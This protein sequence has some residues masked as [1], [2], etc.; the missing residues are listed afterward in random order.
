V[1]SSQIPRN[2]YYYKVKERE[3]NDEIT[4]LI[5]QIFLQDSR[6]IYGQRKI[7]KELYKLEPQVS[8]PRISH[9]MKE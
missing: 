9:I 3:N 7:K 2:T 5:V 6:N 1:F 8:R 4:K